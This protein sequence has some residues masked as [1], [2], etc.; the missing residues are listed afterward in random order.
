MSPGDRGPGL[1]LAGVPRFSKLCTTLSIDG[2]ASSGCCGAASG[3]EKPVED[4][5]RE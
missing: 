4:A 2:T 3:E 1:G 5:V